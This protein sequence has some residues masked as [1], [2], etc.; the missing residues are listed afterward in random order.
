MKKIASDTKSALFFI[1][2]A[3]ICLAFIYFFPIFLCFYQSLT[4][5]S[6]LRETSNFIGLNNY[7]RLLNDADFYRAINN[8]IIWAFTSSFLQALIGLGIAL[9]LNQEFKGRTVSRVL[10]ILPWTTPIIVICVLW[11]WL[12]AHPAGIINYLLVASGVIGQ[13]IPWLA[14]K[15]YSLWITC[16]VWTWSSTPLFVIAVLGAL[17]SVPPSLYDA[18]KVD[19]ANA[20]Q[21][22][23]SIVLPHILP[24]FSVMFTLRLIASFN[25]FSTIFFLTEGGPAGSSETMPIFIFR[26]FWKEYDLGY[27]AAAS[28]T[29]MALMYIIWSSYSFLRGKLLGE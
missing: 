2:P 22:F 16:F 6:L 28:I 3:I 26:R 21:I 8:T 14:S 1:L 9:I 12:F 4:D 20:F 25:H 7:F 19:G 17:Q 23:R 18:A 11:A 5:E 27:A 13:S 10:V 15:S 24:V 29:N